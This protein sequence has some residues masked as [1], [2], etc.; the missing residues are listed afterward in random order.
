VAEAYAAAHPEHVRALILVDAMPNR[1][2][3]LRRA[4]DA[5]EVRKIALRQQG[6]YS[7]PPAP[8]GDDCR[9]AMNAE[10]PLD[11]ADP[12]HPAARSLGATTCS[13]STGEQTFRSL[14]D[15]DFGSV[16]GALRVPV[17]LAFGEGDPNLFELDVLEG[18]LHGA[19]PVVARFPGCG[20]YP[21]LE[22]PDPFFERVRRFLE[23]LEAPSGAARPAAASG[24]T[25]VAID[26]VPCMSAVTGGAGASDALPLIVALHSYGATPLDMVSRLSAL[27]ARARV[28]AP[29]GAIP[30]DGGFGWWPEPELPMSEQAP[31]IAGIA[32]RLAALS[33]AASQSFPTV[34]KPIVTGLSQGGELSSA[35]AVLEPGSIRAALPLRGCRSRSGLMAAPFRAT[36]RSRYFTARPIA[37]IPCATRRTPLTS[38][39]GSGSRSGCTPFPASSTASGP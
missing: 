30:A 32:H 13:A 16:L 27:P 12:R 3:D 24:A 37:F 11:F 22:C 6:L 31:V 10:L 17:L 7:D 8:A 4:I 9:G 14:G 34:G 2:A 29:R 20:H 19:A 1:R 35:I 23:G 25:A 33:R 18:Q 28:V 38:C 5:A 26:G 21:F 36:R 39:A 15:Y